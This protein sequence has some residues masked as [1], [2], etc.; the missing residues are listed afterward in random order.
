MIA[1]ANLLETGLA[2]LRRGDLVPFLPEKNP[3]G[4]ENARFVVN[5][6]D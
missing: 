5:H 2:T 3:Q 1:R 6:Q 4:I